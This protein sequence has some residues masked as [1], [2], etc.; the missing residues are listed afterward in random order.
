MRVSKPEAA[1]EALSA[2]RG[3][4]GAAADPL[5]VVLDPSLTKKVLFFVFL[6][7]DV[8]TSQAEGYCAVILPGLYPILPDARG[9]TSSFQMKPLFGLFHT[10]QHAA[11]LSPYYRSNAHFFTP[12]DG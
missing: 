3:P 11:F 6:R 4:A 7:D 8:R 9:G 12:T 1:H 2:D 10:P 5:P